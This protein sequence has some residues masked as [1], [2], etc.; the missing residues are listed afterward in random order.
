[1]GLEG[2]IGRWSYYLGLGGAVAAVVWRLLTLV[3]LTPKTLL[4]SPHHGLTYEVL[5]KGAFLSL[6][7]TVAT[8]A[9]FVL[10]NRSA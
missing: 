10:K 6:F 5:L 8:A 1:M 4:I 9:R 3:G 7:I 2:Q